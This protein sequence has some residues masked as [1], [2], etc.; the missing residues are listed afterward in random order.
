MISPEMMR[1]M[2]NFPA[3]LAWTISLTSL[4][5]LAQELA[6]IERL[7]PP[8]GLEISAEH[9]RRLV[10]RLDQLQG[11]FE[12]LELPAGESAD[13]QIYLKA[14]DYALLHGEFYKD[15][16][17]AVADRALDS[18]EAR[19][20]Q[21]RAGDRPWTRQRGLVVRGYQS[22]IDG[23]VQP[24]G[25]VIPPDHQFERRVPL[26]V[27]LHGRGDKATDLHF[28]HERETKQG[29]IAPPGAIVLHPFGRHCVGFKHAGEMDVLDAIAAVEREYAIDSDRIVLMGFSMGGAG[30][31]HIGAHY[32]YRF[33]AMSAGAGFVETARYNR[34]EPDEYPPWY[35]QVLWNW[36]DVPAYTRNLFN[37]PVIAYSG[38]IDRQIQ[39]ARVMEEAYREHGQ[40]LTHFIGPGVGH[41][42]APG[43]LEEI[44]Q[45]MQEITASKLASVR[46]PQV[47]LQTRTLRYNR[48][49]WVEAVGLEKHWEDSRIDAATQGDELII[50]TK[51]IS[52]LALHNPPLPHADATLSVDGYVLEMPGDATD[53]LL[54]RQDGTWTVGENVL[55]E[56]GQ[57]ELAKRPGL[58]GPI[59]D[60]FM[61]AFLMVLPSDRPVHRNLA[62]WVDF[63]QRHAIDRWRALMRGEARVKKDVEVTEQDVAQYNLVLWGDPNS[64]QLMRR[65]VE[66]L[67]I[68]WSAETLR[69]NDREYAAGDHVPAMIYPNPL[70]PQKYVVLNSGL[71]FREAHDRTNSLQNPKLPDWAVIDLAQAPDARAPGRIADA[72]FFDESWQWREGN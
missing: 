58:Q 54:V 14:V 27:W 26:Y 13:I 2:N 45:N 16:D 25:L 36:Y 22:P 35:E 64:N 57:G 70:N 4:S 12:A 11:R 49:H 46:P 68:E 33:A 37:L 63:E 34:L 62:R 66:Q 40:E 10:S 55:L 20:E 18:A 44:L 53:V 41:D 42:Y 67:P 72:G 30:A 69:V 8:P 52:S 51:N 39:A 43:M 6:P 56:A 3:I 71:T 19:I 50:T 24:Y 17:V 38:E 28:I 15:S 23:S 5:V 7:L 1:L 48:M 21:V 9:R 29:R 47:A 59:D 61:S 60:A 32:G 31:W 65:I